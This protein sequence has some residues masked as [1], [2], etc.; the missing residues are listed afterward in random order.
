MIWSMCENM[1]IVK[2]RGN[3]FG[4]TEETMNE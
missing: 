2:I 1:S 4:T 3:L